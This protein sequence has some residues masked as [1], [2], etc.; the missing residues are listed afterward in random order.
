MI[1]VYKMCS[2]F[3]TREVS[4]FLTEAIIS[5]ERCGMCFRPTE[6]EVQHISYR[7]PIYSQH[8]LSLIIRACIILYNMIINDEKDIGYGE[9]YHT[10]AFV[11]APRV[12]NE[13]PASLTTIF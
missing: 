2:F 11:V 8:T 3:L 6:E 1:D 5:E 12:V 7:W 10:V 13:A 9:N 4:I